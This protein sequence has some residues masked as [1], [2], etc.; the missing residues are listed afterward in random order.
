MNLFRLLLLALLLI[1]VGYT[2]LVIAEH[3][4]NLFAVF[5]G[6]MAAMT[7]AGQFNLDFMGYLIL[8][9][10]W[11]AWRHHFTPLG[12]ALGVAAFF[13]GILFLTVYLLVVS[14]RVGGD[15]KAMLIGPARAG[16][17]P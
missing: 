11:T 6:D 9:G 17:K 2:A 12:L 4:W 15:V 16:L 13:G 8:S 5:F 14:Y 7:W 3:G 10:L 1:L